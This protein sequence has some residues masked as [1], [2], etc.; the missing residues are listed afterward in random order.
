MDVSAIVPAYNSA[1][2]LRE[3]LAALLASRVPPSE[4]VVVDD[5]STDDTASVA[6][7]MGARVVRLTANA[8]PAGARNRG[9]AAARGDVLF[10]VDADVVVRPDAVERVVRTLAARPDLAA[11]FGSYDARPR[12]PGLVSQFR[13]LLHHYVHQ[14]GTPE[15]FTFWAGC[16]AVRREAFEA[17]G[18]F[19]ER[20][21][22]HFIE[23]IELGYRLRRAGFDIRL[24]RDLQGTHLK[25]WTLRSMLRTDLAYRA[26]PWARLIAESRT[27]PGDLNLAAEQRASV[28]LVALAGLAPVLAVARG[29]FAGVALAALVGVLVLNRGFYRF[30]C[31]ERGLAFALGCFPLHVLHFACGGLGFVWGRCVP[32]ARP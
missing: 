6:A 26:V 20:A 21:V 19:D 29:V 11:V 1:R 12:A 22:R 30:L 5:A 27:A 25:R 14:H 18:R 10:F 7:A 13:N 9:A 4:V 15:A 2:D 23:D 28:V 3:C 8:G 24:D 17:A 32:G 31:R 16:G